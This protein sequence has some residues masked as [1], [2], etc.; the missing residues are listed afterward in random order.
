MF[1]SVFTCALQLSF[2][3]LSI[4]MLNVSLDFFSHS[5]LLSGTFFGVLIFAFNS[6]G[7]DKRSPKRYEPT[8]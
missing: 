3:C 5:D 7:G 8:V 6:Y 1:F 2:M 4:Y